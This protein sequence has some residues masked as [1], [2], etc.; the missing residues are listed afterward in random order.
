MQHLLFGHFPF[1]DPFA[2]DTEQARLSGS[3]RLNNSA[4]WDGLSENA[5]N[6]LCAMLTVD[7]EARISASD[8]LSHPWFD[9][10]EMD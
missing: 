1:S 4:V 10:G 7:P 8:A 9:D 5:R 3:Q 6:L 2:A